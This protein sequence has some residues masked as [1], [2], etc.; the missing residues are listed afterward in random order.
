MPDITCSEQQTL[1]DEWVAKQDRIWDAF[2]DELIDMEQRDS[3]LDL[4]Y[5][6]YYTL[7]ELASL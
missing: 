5:F 2:N 6:E 4:L 3:M 1:Y 7:I